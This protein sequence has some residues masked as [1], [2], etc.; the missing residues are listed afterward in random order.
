MATKLVTIIGTRPEIIK[1]SPLL[2]LFDKD[3]EHILVHSGQHYSKNMDDLFFDELELKRPDFH[4]NI[5]SATPGKQLS[6]IIHDFEKIVIDLSPN[7]ILVHGDTNTTLG[8]ALVAAKYK[9]KNVK[10]IHV[11][12]GA[13]SHNFQQAEEINRKIVD[14]ISDLLFVSDETDKN[15]AIKEGVCKSRIFV[16]GNTVVDSCIRIKNLINHNTFLSKFNLKKENYA[17][18]TFHRQETVDNYETLNN[19]C[20][21][22][23]TIAQNFPIVFP[24]HP[25]TQKMINE[26]EINLNTKNL[27][28]INPV[29]YKDLIGLLNNCRFCITDSGGIQMEAALLN[30]PTLIIRKHTEYMT[31]VDSGLHK[32]TDNSERLLHESNVLINSLS[33]Y[34][35]RKKIKIDITK[36]P[37]QKI[38]N[39]M[40]DFI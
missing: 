11:E 17:L 1:M 35:K 27:Q 32:I 15:N 16:T 36:N 33:D 10:L 25:R 13:R 30:I 6:K 26:Y 39:I 23:N 3:Y 28:I 5:G 19:L 12:A 14:Q 29:G 31:F 4:L 37:S 20:Q 18:L 38:I 21:T 2:P 34:N 24:I 9:D 22:I 40:K 7:A 8:G